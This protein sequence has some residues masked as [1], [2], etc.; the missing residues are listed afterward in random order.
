MVL[1]PCRKLKSKSERPWHR[2][3]AVKIF[4]EKEILKEKE[5]KRNGE[6]KTETLGN[7]QNQEKKKKERNT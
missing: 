5:K 2:Y 3:F 4:F 7:V 1:D 6:L